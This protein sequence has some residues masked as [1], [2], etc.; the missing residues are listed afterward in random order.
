MRGIR[1]LLIVMLSVSLAACNGV[2]NGGSPDQP[3]SNQPGDRTPE[4]TAPTEERYAPRPGDEQMLEG[5]VCRITL[6]IGQRQ[7]KE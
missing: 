4:P 1:L 2:A 7:G 6:H 5:N 3:V